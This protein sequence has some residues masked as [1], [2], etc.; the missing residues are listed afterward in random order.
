M[1][2]YLRGIYETVINQWQI[3]FYLFQE[4]DTLADR[5]HDINQ[6]EDL[7]Y[8][9]SGHT[10]CFATN[11][12][13]KFVPMPLDNPMGK[14]LAGLASFSKFKSTESTRY[15]FPG[16][17]S[18][19]N[20]IYFLDRCFL[21]QRFPTKN[22]KELVVI[23]THNSAYDDGNLKKQQMAFMKNVLLNEYNKGNYVVVGG[24][25][26]QCP[27]GFDNMTFAP[28]NGDSYDQVS[29]APDFLPKD[30]QWVFDPTVATNRKLA[31]P[32]KAGESF[33]TVI[34]F[35]LVS[36]NIRVEEVRGVDLEFAYSDHQPVLMRVVLE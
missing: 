4:V 30:W 8:H 31:T 3:D 32:Y 18:W 6:L 9:L 20:R 19:P 11:Y 23:N 14:V 35:F 34:D 1:Q 15:Q 27:P 22:G 10:S 25:W 16:N 29:I 33:T 2:K 7:T 13:V 24:D 17:Y 28:A 12:N 5:S 21:L 36:P 26:N